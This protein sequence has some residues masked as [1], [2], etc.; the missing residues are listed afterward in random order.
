[1]LDIVVLSQAGGEDY[2]EFRGFMS[3]LQFG[4]VSNE[5]KFDVGKWELG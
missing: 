2:E 3:N 4:I 1:M 5:R